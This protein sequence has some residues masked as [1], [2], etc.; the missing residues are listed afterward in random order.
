LLQFKVTV[1]HTLLP[2]QLKH[3]QHPKLTQRKMAQ[4]LD[5]WN[6]HVPYDTAVAI[7]QLDLKKRKWRNLA[8]FILY[9]NAKVC[10]CSAKPDL[11]SVCYAIICNKGEI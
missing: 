11:P 10:G 9:I 7:E 6:G 5:L 8:S 4:K 2:L 3:K 1:P